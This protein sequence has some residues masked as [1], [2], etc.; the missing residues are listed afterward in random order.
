MSNFEKAIAANAMHLTVELERVQA[1]KLA[2]S[3]GAKPRDELREIADSN[4]ALLRE[5][6]AELVASHEQA[7]REAEMF[8]AAL[9]RL[10]TAEHSRI[11]NVAA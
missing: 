9:D 10:R 3:L 11:R 1:L 8:H 7:R 6:I 4:P 5:W 2:K